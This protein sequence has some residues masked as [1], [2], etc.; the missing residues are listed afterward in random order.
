MEHDKPSNT[1][2]L[3]SVMWPDTQTVYWSRV[4]PN[5]QLLALL[6]DCEQQ[7]VLVFP[8][9]Y[10]VAGQKEKLALYRSGKTVHFVILDAIWQQARKM[11]RQSTYQFS[12]K[13]SPNQARI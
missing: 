6:N 11:Y 1:G 2:K 10:I 5:E 13:A 12:R 4:S 9:L 8:E 7:V 3:I